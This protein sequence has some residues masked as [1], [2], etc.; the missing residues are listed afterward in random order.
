[1]KAEVVATIRRTPAEVFTYITDL[2]N[3]PR[4][5]PVREMRQ[6]TEGPVGIGSQIVQI[7]TFMGQSF[8]SKTEVTGYDPPEVF[9]FKSTSGPMPFEQLFTLS[10]IEEG[11]QLSV[12]LE[13]EPGGFF[14]LAKPLIASA[15]QKQLQEQVDKLKQLLEQ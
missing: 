8:E 3:A 6:L 4:W 10:P 9:A 1:M 11:T 13:G 12:V 5:A 14:K 15:T 2:G 7:I